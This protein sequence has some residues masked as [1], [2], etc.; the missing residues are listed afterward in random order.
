MNCNE[1]S[2]IDSLDIRTTILYEL[3]KT[4]PFVTGQHDHYMESTQRPQNKPNQIDID[5][6]SDI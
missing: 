5:F 3:H 4:H 2:W 1:G 6:A